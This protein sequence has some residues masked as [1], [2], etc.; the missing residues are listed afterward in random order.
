MRVLE[1]IEPKRV[2]E[3][4]E[5]FTKIPHGSGNT[6][7][8]SKYCENFAKERNLFYIRDKAGNV[9]IRKEAAKGYENSTPVIL[10]GHLDMVCEKEEE[11]EVDFEKDALSISVNG[12]FVSANGTTL[13]ADNGLCAA[14]ILALLEDETLKAPKIE[15]VF[16]TDEETGMDGATFFDT[17]IL[18]SNKMINLDSEDEGIFTVSCAGG[19]RA[20]IEIF[21]KREMLAAPCYNLKIDGLSGGHSG[22]EIIKGGANASVLMARVLSKLSEEEL[23][24]LCDIKGGSKD[25]AITTLCEAKILCD[26]DLSDFILETENELKEELKDTDP[27]L[28]LSIEK[29]SEDE[30]VSVISREDTERA[31]SLLQLFPQGVIKMSE[32]IK[33]LVQTSLN[34]GILNSNEE[35]ITVG[36]SIRSSVSAEKEKIKSYLKNL[37]DIYGAEISF[38]GEYPAWEYKK[39][40][41]LRE[42][43]IET[44]EKVY[45]YLPKV[46]A[47]HAG[48]ECGIFA[49]KIENLDCVSCGPQIFDIHTPK[50]K[51]S[52][53]SAQK[54]YLFL[55]KYLEKSK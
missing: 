15:A 46:E 21:T 22:V 52:I 54:F 45:G 8:I 30:E 20:K 2:F 31:V 13:G 36:F 49:G 27:F 39:D 34:L 43:M 12:D 18:S 32:D 16:T 42:K 4:F 29:I 40:S 38:S 3:I 51:F 50:E 28:S 23:F 37:C 25:N 53:S 1:N 7:K 44:F 19:A 5:D 11:C 10:Q 26:A 9:F 14:M 24:L 41:E 55:K 6:D 33:G 48:L 47:I 35:K 17:K